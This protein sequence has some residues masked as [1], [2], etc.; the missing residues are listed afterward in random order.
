M[1][2]DSTVTDL[3]KPQKKRKSTEA[4]VDGVHLRKVKKSSENKAKKVCQVE[5]PGGGVTWNLSYWAGDGVWSFA[6][7]YDP[8]MLNLTTSSSYGF[9]QINKACSLYV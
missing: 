8:D 6:C 4:N 7:K 1:L 5:T 9:I 2:P 3:K